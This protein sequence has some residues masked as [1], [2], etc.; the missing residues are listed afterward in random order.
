[1]GSKTKGLHAGAISITGGVRDITIEV[2]GD[3]TYDLAAVASTTEALFDPGQRLHIEAAGSNDI[4]PF[5]TEATG[6]DKVLVTAPAIAN[7]MAID[8]SADLPFS[9]TGTSAGSTIVQIIVATTDETVSMQCAAPASAGALTV[10]TT[11]LAALPETDAAAIHV[12]V[13][14]H[15]AVSVSGYAITAGLLTR[16]V[17]PTGIASATSVDIGN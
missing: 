2:A 10:P 6:P 11:M 15:D 1:V 9:W 5:S 3:G 14:D 8:P 16:A 7:D 12:V 17:I 4:P 13:I